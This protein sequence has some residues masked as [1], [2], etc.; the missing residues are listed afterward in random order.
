MS[1][2]YRRQKIKPVVQQANLNPY[3]QQNDLPVYWVCWGWGR[4]W[5]NYY[6]TRVNDLQE[7][8]QPEEQRKIKQYYTDSGSR[9]SY[10]Y[11]KKLLNDRYRNLAKHQLHQSL[12]AL[13]SELQLYTFKKFDFGYWFD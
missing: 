10:R 1:R 12:T 13:E 5:E 4:D 2:T 9:R 3:Q 6:S 7:L 11:L 8:R